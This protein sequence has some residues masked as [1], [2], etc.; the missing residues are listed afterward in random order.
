[1]A[2]NGQQSTKNNT[3]DNQNKAKKGSTPEKGQKTGTPPS[4]SGDDSK[5]AAK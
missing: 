3:L 5:K 1:M 2:K 4:K